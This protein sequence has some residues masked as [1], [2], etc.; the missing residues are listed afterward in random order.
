MPSNPKRM[1]NMW[2]HLRTA[3]TVLVVAGAAFVATE[4]PA[5]A[6]TACERYANAPT[7]SSSRIS[8]KVSV[9]CSR[10]VPAATLHGRIKEDRSSLPDIV[11][12]HES[13]TFETS[14]SFIVE[15]SS[16]QD[17]DRIYTEAQINS[18]SPAQS[19]RREMNC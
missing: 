2:T 16:C 1:F 19:S 7:F 15:T 13:L 9:S 5:L 11:H 6:Y 4:T 17:N 3:A 14:S 8:G 12:D 18:E 10:L